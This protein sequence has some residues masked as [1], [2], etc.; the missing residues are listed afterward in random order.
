MTRRGELGV[1]L[2]EVL[3]GGAISAMVLGTLGAALLATMRSTEASREQQHVTQQLRNAFFWLNQDTQSA[4]ASQSSGAAGAADLRWTD[5]ST[6]T[7]YRSEY[8]LAGGDLVR[9]LTVDGVAT[10]RTVARDLAAG[11]FVAAVNGRRMEYT[12]TVSYA[13]VTKT[14]DETVMMRVEGDP[15]TPFATTTPAPTKTATPTPTETA[16][17]TPT[18]TPTDTPTP[19]PTATH[20]PTPTATATAT[21]TPTATATHTPTPT[22]TPTATPT[23]S[24]PW[25]ATGSYTGN[26]ADDRAIG[27]LAFQPD[28]VIV[29]SD[30]N[31]EQASIRTVGMPDDRSKNA[32]GAGAL[33]SNEVQSLTADGFVV[34]SDEDVN[35]SGVTYY[36]TAMKTGANVRTGSYTGD[37]VDNRSITGVGFQPDWVV[38]LGDGEQDFFRPAP[39][40][41]DASYQLD[42]N[43]AVT[44]RIQSL[45]LDG[46][47]LGSDA[48]VNEAGRTYYW[49]AFDV[50]AQVGIGA[51]TGNSVD[52]R[53]ISAGVDPTFVWVKRLGARQSVWRT[54]FVAG[55]RTLYW[56]AGAPVADRIQSLLGGGFTVGADQ[57]V[58]QMNQTY[59]Y[60]ALE[61]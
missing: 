35:E 50:T 3:I 39:L 31:A 38:T 23:P 55:D 4:I 24:G 59:Y 6:G 57:E 44:N 15:L 28:I 33:A 46:F 53:T 2:V 32:T 61:P 49:I 1:G 37:G 16:T 25:L 51:Y 9:T 17:S 36:W 18:P 22:Q 11:G 34:G 14:R 13:G 47:Q 26:G 48:D 56:G 21:P 7:V 5:Y 54:D 30:N 60:L 43:G 45:L 19:T 42:A 58:N 52:G 12:L 20:T 8:A 29:H 10:S 40:A 27:G 41:G